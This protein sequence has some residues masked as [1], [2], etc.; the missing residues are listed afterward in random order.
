MLYCQQES[1]CNKGKTRQDYKSF[2]YCME[3]SEL[4]GETIN[5]NMR[6][7]TTEYGVTEIDTLSCWFLL[8]RNI[9]INSDGNVDILSIN[10][11][12]FKRKLV[13][14]FDKVTSLGFNSLARINK[15]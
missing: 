3:Q 1:A 14:W 4:A 2:T 9:P 10:S 13:Q 5:T 11:I 7:I 8:K 12:M 15:L 6:R